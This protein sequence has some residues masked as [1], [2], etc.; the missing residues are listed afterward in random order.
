MRAAGCQ[1]A[2]SS[3][4]FERDDDKGC[5]RVFIGGQEK[6][7]YQYHPS[8]DL[9]HYWPLKSPSGKNMLLQQGE[10]YPHHRAFWFADT[11]RFKGGRKWEIS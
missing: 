7:V 11:V 1:V 8:L 6:L 10:P 3:I 5:L 2:P 9:P 4:N